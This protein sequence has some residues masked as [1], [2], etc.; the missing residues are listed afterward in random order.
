MLKPLITRMMTELGYKARVRVCQEPFLQG[1]DQALDWATVS[2]ILDAWRPMTR[3]FL[4]L[5]DRDGEPTRKARLHS[6]EAQ[7]QAVL[8]TAGKVLLAEHAWQE[9]EVWLLAAMKDLPKDWAWAKVRGHRDPKETYFRPYAQKRGLSAA[10][11][12]GREPLGREAAANYKRVKRLCPEVADL[13]R[14]VA[15][16]LGGK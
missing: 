9:V 5:V 2:S 10:A 14:R 4:I 15:D 16:A 6:I 13:E 3:L 11:G 1:V 12:G 7:A 8:G